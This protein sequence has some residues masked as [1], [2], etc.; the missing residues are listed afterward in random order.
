MPTATAPPTTSE[1]SDEDALHATAKPPKTPKNSAT[2]TGARRDRDNHDDP[3]ERR[4]A[5]FEASASEHM[6]DMR[7]RAKQARRTVLK[8]QHQ[9]KKKKVRTTVG[10]AGRAAGVGMAGGYLASRSAVKNGRRAYKAAAPHVRRVAGNTARAAHSRATVYGQ[11]Y[12]TVAR[13]KTLRAVARH[14]V[15]GRKREQYRHNPLLHAAMVANG[16][17][18][19]RNM[20]TARRAAALLDPQAKRFAN[21]RHRRHRV[22]PAGLKNNPAA[23]E[24]QRQDRQARMRQRGIASDPHK[25]IHTPDGGWWAFGIVDAYPENS[26]PGHVLAAEKNTPTP[27]SRS[28]SRPPTSSGRSSASN[29][30]HKGGSPV[31]TVATQGAQG[32]TNPA[33]VLE[34]GFRLVGDYVPVN[35]ADWMQQ[36]RQQAGSFR[37]ASQSYLQLAVFMDVRMKMDPRALMG[38]YVIA[39]AMGQTADVFIATANQFWTLYNDRF[40]NSGRGRTMADESSFFGQS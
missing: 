1:V 35:W 38:L 18:T 3:F 37:Q 4:L 20:R 30:T 26:A 2:V 16:R 36:L 13:R 22:P 17:E 11:Y 15:A 8:N 31:A 10:M 28:T 19:T 5:I 40:E 34:N 32:T 12:R 27:T 7:H 23:K 33:S 24:R 39:A 6:R 14:R 9:W 25:P 21:R 29:H